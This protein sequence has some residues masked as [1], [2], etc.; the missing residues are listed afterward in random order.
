MSESHLEKRLKHLEELVRDAAKGLDEARRENL[1]LKGEAKRLT[2]ANL[3]LETEFRRFKALSQRNESVR[4]RL[5]K[6]VKRLDRALELAG[7]S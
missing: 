4:D 2:D 1:K 7:A 3:R 6:A 5:E